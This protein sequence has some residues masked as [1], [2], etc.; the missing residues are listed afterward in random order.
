MLRHSVAFDQ[1]MVNLVTRD[2]NLSV[3]TQLADSL[4]QTFD[5][6]AS[7]VN[8]ITDAKSGVS[9]GKEEILLHGSEVITER[10]GR[11][12]F[13][14]SANS[15]FQTNTRACE[16]LYDVVA[17]YCGLTGKETVLDLYSG[18]GT[19]P[20]WLSDQAA[21]ITGIEIIDTAVADARKNAAMNKIDNCRF[22]AG[23]IRDVFPNLGE[24]PDVIV[25]DPPR[26]GMH[27]DVVARVLGLGSETI[28]YVSCNPATLARDLEMLASGYEVM[29]VQPVDMFPHTYHIESVALLKRR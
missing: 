22:L 18:T 17:R 6:L 10:L 23:D 21:Q 20:I 8:N 25:I 28:V 2:K 12:E 9:L 24:I 1:W 7:I 19:I 26:V 11:F 3:V 14:I 15:F 27:K 13:D 16:K 29:E 5:N 4:A